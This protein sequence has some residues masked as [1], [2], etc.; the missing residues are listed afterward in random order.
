VTAAD[1]IEALVARARAEHARLVDAFLDRHARDLEQLAGWIVASLAAG[2]KVLF[3]GNGGSAA[4]AQHLA[5]EFVNRYDRD[6]PA[7]AAVALATDGSI[8]TSIGND[9]EFATIFARQIEALGRPGD[10][11][12]GITTSGG[13]PNVIAGLRA[14]RRI[15]AKT[16]ALLGRDGGAAAAECDLALIVPGATTARIQEVHILAGHL[17]CECVEEKIQASAGK[18]PAAPTSSSEGR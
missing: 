1:G 8:L 2:G 15:G 7:L 18:T 10:I 12:I 13:S 9:A 3:F 4:D 6:R 16:A 17:V 5:A 14:A 11:A